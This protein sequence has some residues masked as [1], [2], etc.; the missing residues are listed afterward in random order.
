[1][2]EKDD[3]LKFHWSAMT[4]SG[5][6][7]SLDLGITGAATKAQKESMLAEALKDA[8]LSME[9][10]GYIPGNARLMS[11]RDIAAEYG[12]TRQYWEKLLNEGKIL[13]KET[14]AGRITTNLWV[15]GY[16]GNREEVN[17]Y[18]RSVRNVLKTIDRFGK[19]NG[20]ILCPVC[21]EERFEFYVNYAHV[22]G[23]CR[24][25]GFYVHATH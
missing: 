11:P 20:R 22:S 13:Y 10:Q 9:Q 15:R 25:C 16:L 6:T 17:E 4:S 1:M 7:L 23:V 3:T 18:V 21:D 12:N 14:S 2:T 24:G 8:Q 19:K 5:G